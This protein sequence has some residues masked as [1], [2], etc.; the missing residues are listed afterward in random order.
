MPGAGRP[1]ARAPAAAAGVCGEQHV[2]G[3]DVAV[4]LRRI[5]VRWN[6]WD[7]TICMHRQ[8]NVLAVCRAAQIEH[9]LSRVEELEDRRANGSC[10]VT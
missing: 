9:A 2:T 4:H 7:L 6:V 5:T 3:C 8:S 10:A 1:A